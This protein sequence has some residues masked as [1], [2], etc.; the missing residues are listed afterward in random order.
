MQKDCSSIHREHLLK[1]PRALILII[2]GVLDFTFNLLLNF[3]GWRQWGRPAV[4]WK[5]WSCQQLQ[6]FFSASSYFLALQLSWLLDFVLGP[7]KYLE[8]KGWPCWWRTWR[9]GASTRW[10]RSITRRRRSL[11]SL[12]KIPSGRNPSKV[13]F[14]KFHET[15]NIDQECHFNLLTPH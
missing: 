10:R 12:C 9:T 11:R 1:A 7:C 4:R 3:K 2:L 8:T 6:V 5:P 15:F 13:N 14:N